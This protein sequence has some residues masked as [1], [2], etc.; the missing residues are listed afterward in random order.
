MKTKVIF[1]KEPNENMNKGYNIL[2]VFVDENPLLC[3]AHIGQ[4]SECS[5]DY[6]AD[7]ARAKK[8]EYQELKNE[9]TNLVDYN[10]DILN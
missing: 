5:T 1:Y 9:L 4:H 3:Y 8:H 10:L 7:L 6:V 2:A